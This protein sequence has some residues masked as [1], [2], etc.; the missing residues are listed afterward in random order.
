MPSARTMFDAYEACF[1]F[2][3]GSRHPARRFRAERARACMD[4]L[5]ERG[6]TTPPPCAREARVRTLILPN[7][8]TVEVT[9]Y[10]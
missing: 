2:N 5:A 8:R 4:A 10:D 9:H 6:D 7:G 1:Q 3:C